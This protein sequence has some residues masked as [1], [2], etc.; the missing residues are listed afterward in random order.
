MFP[1]QA[2]YEAPRYR[3]L[4]MAQPA[5]AAKWCT[6]AVR[7]TAHLRA[8]VPASVRGRYRR[9]GVVPAPLELLRRRGRGRGQAARRCTPDVESGNRPVGRG[10][11]YA[12]AAAPPQPR[13]CRRFGDA[14]PRWRASSCRSR[15]K[16]AWSARP[17]TTAAGAVLSICSWRFAAEEPAACSP[18][19]EA[20]VQSILHQAFHQLPASADPRATAASAAAPGRAG[21]RRPPLS[22]PAPVPEGA[23]PVVRRRQPDSPRPASASPRALARGLL[24]QVP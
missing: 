3:C 6:G 24:H 22:A 19:P 7:L 4:A 18:V 16:A 17:R 20:P 5:S 9:R 12:R 2:R 13:R 10:V 15:C 8:A 21:S 14:V 1:D 11:P 23:Q